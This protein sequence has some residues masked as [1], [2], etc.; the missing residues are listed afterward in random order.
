MVLLRDVF[1]HQIQPW[2]PIVRQSDIDGRLASYEPTTPLDTILQMVLAAA[3]PHMASVASC[4]SRYFDM[5]LDSATRG[6][7]Q[8]TKLD[9][10]RSALLLQF[11]L[12]GKG[13]IGDYWGLVTYPAQLALRLGLHL[14]DHHLADEHLRFREVV[15]LVDE[16][17]T[18]SSADQ[19]WARKETTRRLFWGIFLQDQF[20]AVF[21]GT[22]SSFDATSIRR[23]LPCD[24][25]HWQEN[26]PVNTHEFVPASVAVQVQM[27]SFADA[28]VGGLAYLIEATEIHAMVVA[29]MIRAR[30]ARRLA[31]SAPPSGR[32]YDLRSYL[33]E[34]LN[35]DLIMT[36]WKARLPPRYQQASYDDNGYMDHNVTLAHLTH[37]T[38]GIL[39]YQWPQ[40][41]CRDTSASASAAAA[42]LHSTLL[43]QVSLVRQAAKE[44][45]K[46]CTR[47][48]MHRSYL[49][50][51]QF[52]YCQFVAA[53]AL[54]VYAEWTAEPV[55]DDYKTISASL[56]E[57][58]KRWEGGAGSCGDSSDNNHK[59]G[60]SDSQRGLSNLASMLLWRLKID[61]QHPEA[62]DLTTPVMRLLRE[63]KSLYQAHPS[64]KGGM[65]GNDSGP[66]CGQ[67]EEQ[68]GMNTALPTSAPDDD[69][70]RVMS[71]LVSAHHESLDNRIFSW[72]DC[73]T[74]LSAPASGGMA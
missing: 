7:L 10:L 37:N 60:D 64:P 52:S 36:N 14:E 15:G 5:L 32:C 73:P 31:S 2:L 6:I 27:L 66:V 12:F 19:T 71:S 11:L 70:D 69:F 72:Q 43:P 63:V 8:L 42:S 74:D 49:V 34:F 4:H 38:T 28:H 58:A 35:L 50:S 1:R 17:A 45:A 54:L 26:W 30:D 25:R 51:P 67:A 40:L 24:G 44:I 46:I 13:L 18:T 55:D 57:A 23:L 39:L 56:A 53:R 3:S 62:I 21:S 47:F 61:A 41:V 48:L 59:G 29:F 65:L 68:D 9:D 16:A 22:G 33:Q 20:A